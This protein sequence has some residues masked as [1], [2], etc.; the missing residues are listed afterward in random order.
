[1]A[2][3]FFHL[4]SA[5]KTMIDDQSAVFPDDE[6]A[7]AEARRIA[8]NFIDPMTGRVMSE[9]QD[10]SLEVCDQRGRSIMKVDF[11][12]VTLEA[13][14]GLVADQPSGSRA[15]PIKPAVQLPEES[16]GMCKAATK[17]AEST[18]QPRSA[19]EIL[20]AILGRS[21]DLQEESRRIVMR[22]RAQKKSG[23]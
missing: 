22:P 1:M 21:E 13:M 11:A 7:R 15:T 10:W 18:G 14:E 5:G 4:R 12:Q 6:A 8:R 20:R 2:R 16:S 23:N 3:F 17:T 9:W 19:A